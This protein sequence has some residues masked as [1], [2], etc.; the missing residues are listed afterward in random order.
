MGRIIAVTG[1]CKE[2]RAVVV[3]A[4]ARCIGDSDVTRV[5][6]T[7]CHVPF[8][9]CHEQLRAMQVIFERTPY[10]RKSYDYDC[11]YHTAHN[12]SPVIEMR[13]RMGTP[14]AAMC[15]AIWVATL[16]M[17]SGTESAWALTHGDLTSEDR[18]AIWSA[19]GVV[20]QVTDPESRDRRRCDYGI[21]LPRDDVDVVVDIVEELVERAFALDSILNRRLLNQRWSENEQ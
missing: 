11:Q 20:V 18:M 17:V 7:A 1:R 14:S 4:F 2:N 9:A 10:S 13:K 3:N 16:R 19:G 8:T 6:F 21:T 5:P 15:R 12:Y